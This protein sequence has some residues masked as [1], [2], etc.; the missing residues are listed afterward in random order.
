MHSGFGRPIV[1]V[2]CGKR[3]LL[4][5]ARGLDY[6]PSAATPVNAYDFQKPYI[7][8]WLRFIGITDIQTVVVE[9]TLLGPE[10]DGAARA[11]AKAEAEEAA[12]ICAQKVARHRSQP[13]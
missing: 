1:A 8:T 12:R 13:E 2:L 9:K 7:E 3:A 11:T 6:S 10:V 4:F 5:C